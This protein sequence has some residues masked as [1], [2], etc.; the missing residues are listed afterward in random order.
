VS[1]RNEPTLRRFFDDV[2]RAGNATTAVRAMAAGKDV[3]IELPLATTMD[4]AR[5]IVEVHIQP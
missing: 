3:L 4:D 2:E 5:R 1:E